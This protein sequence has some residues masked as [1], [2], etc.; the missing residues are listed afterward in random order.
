MPI[1]DA[2]FNAHR[3]D[4]VLGGKLYFTQPF[5]GGIQMPY[6]I[7]LYRFASLWTWITP[8]HVAL[9][10]GVT[11]VSDVVAGALLYP[12]VLRAWGHRRTAVPVSG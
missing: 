11:V 2:Q 8:D 7:G 4:W 1:G 10:R 5:V 6:A 12:L 3:L 9:I